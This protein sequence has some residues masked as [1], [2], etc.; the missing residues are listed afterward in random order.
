VRVAQLDELGARHR[1]LGRDVQLAVGEHDDRGVRQLGAQPGAEPNHQLGV[2][3]AHAHAV[4][5]HAC[6]ELLDEQRH[7]DVL[8]LVGEL[9]RGQLLEP[10]A[11]C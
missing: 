8:Q 5:S 3:V 2:E 11:H 7:G 6:A 4:A 9:R 10:G 1:E